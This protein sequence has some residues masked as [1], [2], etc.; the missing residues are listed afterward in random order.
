MESLWLF[1]EVGGVNYP[2]YTLKELATNEE[3]KLH[4]VFLIDLR[5]LNE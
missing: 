1:G 2:H 5:R 3:R 4:S